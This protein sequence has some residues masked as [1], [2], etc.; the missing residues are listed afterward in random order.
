MQVPRAFNLGREYAFEAFR[1]LLSD[2]TI[3]QNPGTMYQAAKRWHRFLHLVPEQIQLRSISH[4]SSAD[5]DPNASLTHFIDS[6]ESFRFGRRTAHE[7]QIA[8]PLICHPLCRLQS[9]R[10]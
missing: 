8:A 2:H 7:H 4:I 5:F 6:Y 9:D 3:V 10:T 1:G